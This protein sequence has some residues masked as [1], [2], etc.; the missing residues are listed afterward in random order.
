[1]SLAW[2]ASLIRCDRKWL[3]YCTEIHVTITIL[4]GVN[5]LPGSRR[6]D[7]A[8]CL[9]NWMRRVRTTGRLCKAGLSSPMWR[10]YRSYD[11]KTEKSSSVT[12]QI[13]GSSE[14]G[15][16][17]SCLIINLATNGSYWPLS[18]LPLPSA[19]ATILLV[20]IPSKMLHEPCHWYV[21]THISRVS[22][23]LDIEQ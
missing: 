2:R 6:L 19:R 4:F 8:S 10:V 23:Y 20:L 18:Y 11:A 7:K 12:T 5:L 3:L 1:M 17:A 21:N 22:I 14:T 15:Q 16:V 13:M 9:R